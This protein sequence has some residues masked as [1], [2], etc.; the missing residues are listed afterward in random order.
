MGNWEIVRI[1]YPREHNVSEVY[2]KKF[3]LVSHK[4]VYKVNQAYLEI[5]NVN[6]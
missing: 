5:D 3:Y 1:N 4:K 6:Q 2:Q